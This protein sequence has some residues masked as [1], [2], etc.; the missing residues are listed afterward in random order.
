MVSIMTVS[1]KSSFR[2]ISGHERRPLQKLSQHQQQPKSRVRRVLLNCLHIKRLLLRQKLLEREVG[3]LDQGLRS[4]LGL[5]FKHS[6]CPKQS[7]GIWN[8]LRILRICSRNNDIFSLNSYL[9]EEKLSLNTWLIFQLGRCCSCRSSS[10]CNGLGGQN[11]IKEETI[12]KEEQLNS[13]KCGFSIR[14]GRFEFQLG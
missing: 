11:A 5:N 6:H 4:Q 3:P 10:S 13:F 2:Q 1:T 12:W 14:F 9:R 8:I 7:I